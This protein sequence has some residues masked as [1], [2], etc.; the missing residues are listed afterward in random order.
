MPKTKVLE[1]V[2]GGDSPLTPLPN[3][4]QP[5]DLES[6]N[7]RLR[8]SARIAAKNQMSS[9][10]FSNEG[11]RVLLSVLEFDTDVEI[12][13]DLNDSKQALA[14]ITSQI[15]QA[16][17]SYNHRV[18][19]SLTEP[20]DDPEAKDPLTIREAQAS[21]YWA[22][23]LGAIYEELESLRQKGVYEEI[24][25]LPPGRKAIGSKWVLHIKR[26]K[27]GLI[28]RFKARLVAKG[29]TQV[30]GQ[31]FTHTFA[32]V[33]RWDS[34]RTI[35]TLAA[36]LDYELRHIDVK[37]AFL[38]GPLEEE[39]YMRKPD[40]LGTG[41]WRLMKGLY[42]L[43]QAG[44]QWYVELNATLEKLSFKRTESDWSVHVRD[45]G[46]RKSFSATSV[47]DMLIASSSKKESDEITEGLKKAYEI[48]DLGDVDWLLGCRITRWRSRRCLKVDQ[49][50]YTLAILREFDFEQ[51][52]SKTTPFP[53]KTYLTMD[54]CP[55]TEAERAAMQAY[56]FAALVGKLMYLATCTR[57]DIA[58]VVR[59]L[60]RF[61]GNP[62]MEHWKC[63]KHVL[64]YLRGTT[65]YGILLGNKDSP[66]PLFKGMSDSDWAQGEQRKSISTGDK[67]AAFGFWPRTPSATIILRNSNVQEYYRN[68]FRNISR[69][70]LDNIGY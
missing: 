29:F 58:Y 11:G 18:F 69:Q 16:E 10:E 14:S 47:D 30:P 35:L 68:K 23:W 38:N 52:K 64:R 45:L 59:E 43:K 50:A 17:R 1:P 20:I 62:G 40:M 70:Y 55:K 26:N 67:K 66:Y 53:P 51:G 32:P 8:R 57:P 27:D 44:R 9:A 7:E 3:E 25:S 15:I 12:V 5:I 42:G 22:E 37:T 49:E 31:D 6:V 33:A 34:I 2:F 24:D 13:I 48:S 4:A 21:I 63:A 28:S 54:L 36:T 39:L 61:M 65:S 19:A 60:A 46:D 41:Y 56:P